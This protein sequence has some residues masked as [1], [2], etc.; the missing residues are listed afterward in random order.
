VTSS[1]LKITAFLEASLESNA[2]LNL[3]ARVSCR[4]VPKPPNVSDH[5]TNARGRLAPW[6]E[7]S[8]FSSQTGHVFASREE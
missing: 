7:D 2:S 8:L 6:K 5:V 1:T 3:L 4:P